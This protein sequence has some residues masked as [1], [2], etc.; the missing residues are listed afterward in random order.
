MENI[1]HHAH[2]LLSFTMGIVTGA[3]LGLLFAPKSGNETREQLK[4]L[5]LDLK[6]KI[7]D[8]LERSMKKGEDTLRKSEEVLA[9]K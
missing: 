3:A 8:T 7:K 1:K 4:Q 2:P 9:Q 6:G 5:P